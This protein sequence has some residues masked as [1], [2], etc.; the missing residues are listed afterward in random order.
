[1]PRKL[2][3]MGVTN[4][5]ALIERTYR[6]SH[7]FQWVRE[8]LINSKEAGATRVHFGIE[9]QGVEN[10]G[11]YRRLI[12]DNGPGMTPDKMILFLNTYGGSGKPI[13]GEHE[14]FGHGFKTST[15]PWNRNG[16]VVISKSHEDGTMAMVR[17]EYDAKTN[18]YGARLEDVDGI[19]DAVYAPYDAT[20]TDGVDYSKLLP[21][22][23]PSG[24][25]ILLLG[26]PEQPDTVLG[27]YDREE[28]DLNGIARY[29]NSRMWD[30]SG[31]TVTVDYFNTSNRRQWPRHAN[32]KDI[33]NTTSKKWQSRNIRGAKYH[34]EFEQKEQGKVTGRV[35]S[36]GTVE[37]ADGLAKVHWFVRSGTPTQN[38]SVARYRGYIG[39]LYKNEVYTILSHPSSFRSFGIPGWLKENVFLIIEP[40]EFDRVSGAYPNDARTLLLLGGADAGRALP[41]VEWANEF[42]N[43]LPPEIQKKISEHF[44]GLNGTIRDDRWKARL[45]ERF[46]F[47][48]KIFKPVLS[49]KGSTKIRPVQPVGERGNGHAP[50]TSDGVRESRNRTRQ[51]TGM[52]GSGDHPAE[53]RKV[54]GGLPDYD[55]VG[56]DEFDEPWI[57]ASW[58]TPNPG[59]ENRGRVLINRDHPVIKKHIAETQ[60]TFVGDDEEIAIEVLNVYG[61]LGVAHVAHSEQMKGTLMSE[62]E[63]SENLRSDAA[64][65]MALLGMWQ[66]DTILLP[67]LA[68]KMAKRKIA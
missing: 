45:E 8:A 2:L 56:K 24:V 60:R 65:T 59:N 52:P 35:E 67:R 12:L 34:I 37:V 18:E 62:R 68:G 61:E 13:G 10:K 1:M 22:D 53:R 16:I 23:W 51:A 5:P 33:P 20:D 29:L 31:L 27:A 17:L 21:E 50:G 4:V 49:S 41:A 11:V 3:A 42:A 55:H 26:S 38:T 6:E 63:V 39:H 40:K 58:E 43:K 25:A 30:L 9:W 15:L 36:S 64:L 54:L 57:L 44:E 7:D 19:R 46:G 47:L 66:V 28:G 14:N 48:W 32:D